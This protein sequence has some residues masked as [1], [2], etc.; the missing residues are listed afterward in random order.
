MIP[1]IIHHVWPGDDPFREKFHAW[2]ESWMRLHPDWTFYFW[3]TSNLPENI[4]SLARQILLDPSYSITPKSDVLRFEVLRIYGGIYVDTD[5]ECLRPFD[6]FLNLDMFTGFEDDYRRVCPSL[7]GC[8][9]EHHLLTEMSKVSISR[10]IKYGAEVSN[11]RPHVITSVKPFTKIMQ[12]YFNDED[13]AQRK[14]EDK[15][16]KIFSKDY[17]Y[18]VYFNEKHLL[19]A[20]APYAYAK[21]HW[22][23]NDEEGWTKS[24]KFA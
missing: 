12:K 13:F 7:I 4:N 24:P 6:N 23:G 15:T 3:R 20:D 8:V 10:A 14:V 9:P 22:T 2:R 18:P 19:S 11:E 5:M 16:V 1:K 17:F 21:H